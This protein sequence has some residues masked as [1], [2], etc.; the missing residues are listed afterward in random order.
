MTPGLRRSG[1]RE[2]RTAGVHALSRRAFERHSGIFRLGVDS[3]LAALDRGGDLFRHCFACGRAGRPSD[4]RSDWTERH[5]CYLRNSAAAPLAIL[6]LCIVRPCQHAALA[7]AGNRARVA[8]PAAALA[9]LDVAPWGFLS[10]AILAAL[11]I[12]S[13]PRLMAGSSALP[14]LLSLRSPSTSPSSISPGHASRAM[15]PHR[16]TSPMPRR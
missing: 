9:A 6:R 4:I 14:P 5:G 11:R 3:V 8:I 15:P 10:R 2:R 13:L 7:G 1:E 12:R 16:A